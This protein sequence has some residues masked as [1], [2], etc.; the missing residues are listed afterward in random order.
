[1]TIPVLKSNV[2][3]ADLGDQNKDHGDHGDRDHKDHGDRHNDRDRD[4]DK[5]WIGIGTL[6]YLYCQAS[7][8]E[9]PQSLQSGYEADFFIF[10]NFNP[11]TLLFT[12]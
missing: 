10:Y 5:K 6:K 4:K 2:A 12:K 3:Y 11:F 9:Y 7:V 8:S 1:M